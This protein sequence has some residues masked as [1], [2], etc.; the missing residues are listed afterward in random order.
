MNYKIKLM[1]LSIILNL[2]SYSLGTG[3]GIKKVRFDDNVEIREFISGTKIPSDRQKSRSRSTK[4]FFDKTESLGKRAVTPPAPT[5]P[6]KV[7]D[8]QKPQENLPPKTNASSLP[9]VQIPENPD[10]DKDKSEKHILDKTSTKPNENSSLSLPPSNP[11]LSRKRVT[12][13]KPPENLPPNANTGPL[14]SVQTLENPDADERKKHILDKTS[15]KPNEDSN[16]STPDHSS[17]FGFAF[18]V[19][20]VLT[21]GG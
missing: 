18:L 6:K 4:L 17:F 5:P 1:F 8:Q 20:D 9:L 10:A 11:P 19:C 13:H 21:C 14:S 12:D 2:A 15:T 16:H 7:E 3:A